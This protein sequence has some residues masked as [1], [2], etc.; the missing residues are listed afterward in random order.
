MIEII[1]ILQTL[2]FIYEKKYVYIVLFIGFALMMRLFSK[3]KL[4]FLIVPIILTQLLYIACTLYVSEGFRK[5]WKKRAKRAIRKRAKRGIKGNINDARRVGRNYVGLKKK[6]NK[7]KATI[8]AQNQKIKAQNSTIT[9]QNQ[10][11][12]NTNTLSARY[13]EIIGNIHDQVK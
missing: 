6:N 10:Q 12:T 1:I 11:L 2:F 5:K 4:L 9:S 3:N 8:H 13:K 7:Q